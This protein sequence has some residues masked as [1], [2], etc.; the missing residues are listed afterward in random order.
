MNYGYFSATLD[1]DVFVK[2]DS[3]EFGGE[4]STQVSDLEG[5]TKTLNRFFSRLSIED[6]CRYLRPKED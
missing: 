6:T 3:I 1:S 2:S 4:Q 5:C